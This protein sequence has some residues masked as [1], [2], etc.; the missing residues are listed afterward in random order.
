M[1]LEYL[2]QKSPGK[3]SD[4]QSINY[5]SSISPLVRRKPVPLPSTTPA[6]STPSA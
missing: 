5:Q 1:L 2:G 6:A 4:H 3:P